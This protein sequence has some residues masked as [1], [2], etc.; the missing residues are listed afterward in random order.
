M[1]AGFC[2]LHRCFVAL[3]LLFSMSCVSESDEANMQVDYEGQARADAVVVTLEDG[4]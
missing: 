3:V 4:A 1:I 2:R